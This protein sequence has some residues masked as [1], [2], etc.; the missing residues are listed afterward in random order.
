MIKCGFVYATAPLTWGAIIDYVGLTPPNNNLWDEDL[1]LVYVVRLRIAPEQ[2]ALH[3]DVHA[4]AMHCDFHAGAPYFKTILTL[5][6]YAGPIL[7]RI[8]PNYSTLVQQSRI[9]HEKP[10]IWHFSPV[11]LPVTEPL[12]QVKASKPAWPCTL[13]TPLLVMRICLRA[14]VRVS[15]AASIHE[16]DQS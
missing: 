7:P 9:T 10:N 2:G 8:T 6:E 4:G 11:M 14:L 1:K 13:D 12:L 5:H 16:C 3:C 15:A